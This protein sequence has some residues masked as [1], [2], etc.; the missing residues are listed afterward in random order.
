MKSLFRQKE[1]EPS[2]KT[3][4]VIGLGRFGSA[5]AERLAAANK[6]LIVADRDPD[7]VK[8]LREYTPYAYVVE[9]L[10]RESLDEIGVANC[11]I[12]IVG[13]GSYVDVSIMTV[14]H[15]INLGIPKVYAKATSRDHGDILTRLGAEVVYP[16]KEAGARVAQRLVADGLVSI[17]A[18]NNDINVYE[19]YIPR[20]LIGKTV[21]EADLRGRYGLNI[22]AIEVN[23]NQ[24]ITAVEPSYT[25]QRGDVIVVIGSIE[26]VQK[27]ENDF[28][29]DFS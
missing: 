24:T 25:F 22:A 3:Y 17:F 10:T 13:I 19:L 8:K 23:G 16:E 4:A 29:G 6:Q 14:L 2:G 27:F 11:D 1:T 7:R 12:A 18:L 28:E 5:V 9:K 15:L 20:P 26:D 21:M